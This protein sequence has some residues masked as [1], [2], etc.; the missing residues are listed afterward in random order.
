MFFKGNESVAWHKNKQMKSWILQ[1]DWKLA[2]PEVQLAGAWIWPQTII[3]SGDNEWGYNSKPLLECTVH[4]NGCS[5]PGWV[6]SYHG[7]L[8]GCTRDGVPY[9]KG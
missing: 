5:T 6:P 3:K 4:L 9:D 8:N 7:N 1:G 2:I